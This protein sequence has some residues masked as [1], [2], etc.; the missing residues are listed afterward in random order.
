MKKILLAALG[1]ILL[2]SIAL[3][4]GYN[5]LVTMNES[6]NS[7]WSQVE[8]QLQRRSDLVPNLVATVQGMAQ[9]EKDVI[10]S[11]TEARA[12]LNSAQTVTQTAEAN[13]QLTS[14][15]SR[16]LVIVENYPTIKSDA[17]FRQL[18]DELAG[19]ENR[20]AVARQDY[21]TA[22]EGYN[23]II[24]TFPTLLYAGAFGFHPH[25]Y[26]KVEESAKEVPKV[27]F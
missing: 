14:S 11:V 8:N 9:Q 12:K 21:N 23:S 2:I 16:L 10:N 13:E 4:S 25:E 24:K 20:I 27:S 1:I 26:F 18:A 22:V 7:K 6:V 5:S 15:L 3:F 19:T 17:S